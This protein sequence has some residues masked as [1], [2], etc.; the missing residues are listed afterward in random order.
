MADPFAILVRDQL[1]DDAI[2]FAADA[3]EAEAC[4]NVLDAE[5][6]GDGSRRR[7]QA[8][9]LRRASDLCLL[10]GGFDDAVLDEIAGGTLHK[11]LHEARAA[12]RRRKAR[13]AGGTP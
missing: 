3:I 13:S 11:M 4:A 12:E 6:K 1:I 8:E 2:G 9:R 5:P 10:L 7:R